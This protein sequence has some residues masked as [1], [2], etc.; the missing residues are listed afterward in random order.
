[1]EGRNINRCEN[2]KSK[3]SSRGSQRKRA[4][5]GSFNT[6]MTSTTKNSDL[7]VF[8]AGE[9]NLKD[10]PENLMN[11]ASNAILRAINVLND[12]LQHMTIAEMSEKP[13]RFTLLVSEIV[14]EFKLFGPP[15]ESG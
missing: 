14:P 7:V 4:E 12:Q 8:H 15:T 11:K 1:M 9:M 2:L 6:L 5:R 10:N 3:L 13:Y